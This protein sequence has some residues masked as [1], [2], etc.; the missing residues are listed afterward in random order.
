MKYYVGQ[1][2]CYNGCNMFV[3][4]VTFDGRPR[5]SGV[6]PID[7]DYQPDENNFVFI[8]GLVVPQY[9]LDYLTCYD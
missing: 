2:V 7:I 3:T 9:M 4:E 6:N 8:P 1:R 5:V